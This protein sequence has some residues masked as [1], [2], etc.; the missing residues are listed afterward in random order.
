MTTSSGDAVHRLHQ[1]VRDALGRRIVAAQLPAG[2]VLTLEGIQATYAVSRPVAR[3]AVRVLQ[4]MGLVT[5]RRRVGITVLPR[6]E[7]NVFDPMVIRWRL[8]GEGRRDQLVSLSEL[9]QGFE[10]IAA[11]LAAERAE[12][13]H[14]GELA[15]AVADMVVH[16]ASGD[17]EAY[18]EAD[19]TFHRVLL[20]AGGNEML[21]AFGDVV[22][23][24][25]AGRTHH[26]LMPATPNPAAIELHEKVAIAVRTGDPAGAEEAMRAI[27]DEAAEAVSSAPD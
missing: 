23:E 8:D 18:L 7:W 5:T 21:A 10:P 17:L 26:H 9:R 19:T 1:S 24:L 13:R 27:I 4:S 15:R 20:Q 16:A 14:H 2:A 22:A 12:P 11:R 3:E 25:L 6:T